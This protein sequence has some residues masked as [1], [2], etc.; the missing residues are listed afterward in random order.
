M[1]G[2]QCCL[3]LL[4]Q[5]LGMHGEV[6]SEFWYFNENDVYEIVK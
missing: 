5:S 4:G 6:C 1:Y 3:L 2:N